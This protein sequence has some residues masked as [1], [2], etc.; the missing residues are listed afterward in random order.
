MDA[1]RGHMRSGASWP[2]VPLGQPCPVR[3][4]VEVSSQPRP[5]AASTGLSLAFA[6]ETAP[7]PEESGQ[8]GW[9]GSLIGA[10]DGPL[11]AEFT[12]V[13]SHEVPRGPSEVGSETHIWE[14][15]Q[16]CPRGS[17]RSAWSHTDRIC[18]GQRQTGHPHG[19]RH[20]LCPAGCRAKG[21]CWD[22]GRSRLASS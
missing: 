19:P 14:R 1:V 22:P 17:W 3:R 11:V 18:W 7:G 9:T 21:L 6:I 16:I 15:A 5:V 10:S 12:R 4:S 20:T 2:T 13:L 8:L